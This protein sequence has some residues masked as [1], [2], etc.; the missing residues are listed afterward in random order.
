MIGLTGGVASGKSTVAKRLQALGAVVLGT[1]KFARDA[2]EP[3]PQAGS[4]ERGLPEVIRDDQSIDRRLLGEI[5]FAQ[6]EK[7][8][9]VGRIIHP[10][11]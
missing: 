3:T 10:R 4:S 2:V 9:G 5:V 7:K 8:E 11:C 1:D 6:E